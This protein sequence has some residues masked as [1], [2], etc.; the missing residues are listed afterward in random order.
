M[1]G[2][3]DISVTG[4]LTGPGLAC[5]CPARGFW[6]NTANCVRL[7]LLNLRG[8]ASLPGAHNHQ[9]ACAAYAV[10]RTLGLA[11]RVIEAGLASFVQGLPH[12]SQVIAKTDGVRY[13]NDSKATNVDSAAQSSAGRLTTFAGSAVACRK[14]GGLEAV[15]PALGPRAQGLCDWSRGRQFLPCNCPARLR[16]APRWRWRWRAGP[17]R[18]RTR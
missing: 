6:Q 9:N 2:W 17:R 1:I 3:I 15:Q 8:M 14:D 10:C 18:G 12:R 11:P 16:C 13:V 4:K 5:V 7:P